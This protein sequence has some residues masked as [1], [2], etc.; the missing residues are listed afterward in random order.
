[1]EN[2]LTSAVKITTRVERLGI[3]A[4]P[5]GPYQVE[6][7]LNPAVYHDRDGHLIVMMRSVAHGNQ[8]RLEMIRQLWADGKPVVDADGNEAPF[9]RVGFALVPQ[10]AYERRRRIDES[11]KSV[12]IGGEGCEDPRVTFIA[13][14]DRYM[15]CYTAFGLAGPRIAIAWSQDGYKWHRLGLLDIPETFGLHPDDKDAAFFPEPVMSPSGEVSLALYHRPMTN[16]PARDGMDVVQ[17]TLAAAPTDRQCIRIAY[18]PLYAVRADFANILKVTE[19]ELVFAPLDAWGTFKCGAGTAPVKIT[20]GLLAGNLLEIFHGVDQFASAMRP[21]GYQGRYAGGVMLHDGDEPHRIKY[22]SPEPAIK[23]ETR[24]ELEGIV[25]NVVFPTGI[26]E[27]ADLATHDDEHVYDVFYG[28]ADRLIGRF[29]LW[30]VV[31]AL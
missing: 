9:E 10:A 6:G 31:A 20:R 7:V 18:I 3:V 13:E 24:D 25:N 19:S 14:L 1:M 12:T 11:G 5:V 23:P 27:R 26:V 4:S 21:S 29:R 30:V 2:N 16:I 17:S 28:M 8:S 15:M 22:V